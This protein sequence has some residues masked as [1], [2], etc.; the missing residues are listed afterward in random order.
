M[1]EPTQKSISETIDYLH[2]QAVEKHK[3][4]ELTKAIDFYLES[5]RIDE[6]QPDW[7]YGNV[8][9]LLAQLERFNEALKLGEQAEKLH[10]ES[11]VVYRAMGIGFYHQNIHANTIEKY[12]KAIK[13]NYK[14][15]KWVY[16]TLLKL[17]TDNNK[18]IDSFLTI[19][20]AF[21]A[22]LDIDDVS[23]YTGLSA[24]LLIRL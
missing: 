10:P 11:D 7:I 5:I 1:A 24:Q 21:K 13:I 6:N 4:G 15:P 18:L 19:K 9:I 2:T 23:Q 22:E 17:L 8:I 12:K 3:K 14:Q 20:N 16:F